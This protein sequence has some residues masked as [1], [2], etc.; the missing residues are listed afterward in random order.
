[1][2]PSR[3]P[4]KSPTGAAKRAPED[5]NDQF[6]SSPAVQIDERYIPQ[7]VPAERIEVTKE[8]VPEVIV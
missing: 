1:M 7:K 5:A 8:S 2:T 3:R 4:R 6:E